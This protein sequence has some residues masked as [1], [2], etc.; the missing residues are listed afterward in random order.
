MK[1]K[2]RKPTFRKLV[3]DFDHVVNAY[4]RIGG[5]L[6]T[7]RERVNIAR[8]CKELAAL[9]MTSVKYRRLLMALAAGRG[10]GDAFW[11]RVKAADLIGQ[12]KMVIGGIDESN[13]Y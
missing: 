5:P 13:E 6:W 8:L 11:K 7:K 2:Y 4:Q 10:G 9:Q 3:E 1:R 12:A